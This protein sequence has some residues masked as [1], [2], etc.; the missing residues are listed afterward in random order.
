M[1]GIY[2]LILEKLL[3]G[4]YYDSIKMPMAKWIEVNTKGK[5][6][7]MLIKGVFN[8]RKAML[9]RQAI[10]DEI[11]D[12]FG[13]TSMQRDILKRKIWIEKEYQKM[14]LNNDKSMLV[15]ITI[16]EK[17]L[18]R[19]M[20]NTK[21][22]KYMESIISIKAALKYDINPES[23]SIEEYFTTIKHL[24]NGRTADKK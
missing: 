22:P 17:E 10:Q 20:A 8:I 3:G 15:H 9:A 2:Y 11:I 21:A 6:R 23:I 4:T 18:E 14:I 12:T 16:A 5:L 7:L 1:Q 24:E 13:V 19:I